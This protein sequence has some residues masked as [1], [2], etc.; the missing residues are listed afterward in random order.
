MKKRTIYDP[1]EI[2]LYDDYAEVVLYNKDCEEIARTLIDS[3]DVD[4]VK[5]YKWS[6]KNNGYAVNNKNRL[7][8][9]RFVINCPDDKVV[10]HINHN[11]LDNRKSNLRIC[12][13]QQNRM[14]NRKQPNNTSGCAG[15]SFYKPYNKWRAYIQINSRQIFLG[16]FNTKE[17]AIEA[18]K[19][20]E[21]EYFG[22]YRNDNK[23]D[24]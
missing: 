20:A 23:D 13:Q 1:N 5:Q 24:E 8:L 12:T 2:V 6:I 4:K 9:H 10:D 16:Y 11:P 18:R 17:D 7:L 15:V 19:Q 3:E 22:E 21:L 14:N